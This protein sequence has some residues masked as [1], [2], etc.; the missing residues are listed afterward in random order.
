MKALT[1]FCVAIALAIAPDAQAYETNF[2]ACFGLNIGIHPNVQPSNTIN[3]DDQFG[4][5]ANYGH[6]PNGYGSLP[7]VAV[8]YASLN[9][10]D[11]TVALPYLDFWESGYGD[12]NY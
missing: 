3:F 4:V 10:N 9:S 2:T 8:T 11:Y 5:L 7:P 1:F 12:L 6:I